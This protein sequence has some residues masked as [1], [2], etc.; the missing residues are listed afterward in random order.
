[1]SL[2]NSLIL[3]LYQKINKSHDRLSSV[4]ACMS[5]EHGQICQI[6]VKNNNNLGLID[7]GDVKFFCRKSDYKEL[8]IILI[9]LN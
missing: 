2:D 9:V 6:E 7:V 5:I 1:M 8:K 3:F 4:H